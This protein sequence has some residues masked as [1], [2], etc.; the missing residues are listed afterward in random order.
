MSSERDRRR[1][2]R[3]AHKAEHK[4][5]ERD[6]L[7]LDREQLDDLLD[8]VEERL[9]DTDCDHTLR[10]SRAWADAWSVPWSAPE[11]G[12]LANGAGCDCEVLANL[13][14]DERV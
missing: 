7:G 12:L 9:A 4:R 3:D 10:H 6:L 11:A 1:M 2:L 5:A 13:D 14:P 8:H